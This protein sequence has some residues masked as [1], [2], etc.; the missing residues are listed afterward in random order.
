MSELTRPL[1]AARTM[2]DKER[3]WMEKIRAEQKEKLKEPTLPDRQKQALDAKAMA[4][5]G[6]NVTLADSFESLKA[7]GTVFP[8]VL[9]Y[10]RGYT[11]PK[12]SFRD[13]LRSLSGGYAQERVKLALAMV[14]ATND[15]GIEVEFESPMFMSFQNGPTMASANFLLCED[16]TVRYGAQSSADAKSPATAQSSHWKPWAHDVPRWELARLPALPV[17]CEGFDF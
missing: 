8:V 6:V 17:V 4:R 11:P 16:G 14:V 7:K 9:K 13:T 2:T 10:T 5:F 15:N 3:Q 12:P 1:K